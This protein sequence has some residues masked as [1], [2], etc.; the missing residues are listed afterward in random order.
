MLVDKLCELSTM[1]LTLYTIIAHNQC[2]RI[3]GGNEAFLSPVEQSVNEIVK[4]FD[5]YTDFLSGKGM[6]VTQ[7]MHYFHRLQTL[8]LISLWTGVK[9]EEIKTIT[10]LS[11][12]FGP[13]VIVT[14]EHTTAEITAAYKE[15]PDCLL[16]WRPMKEKS[17]LMINEKMRRLILQ[18]QQTTTLMA[19]EHDRDADQKSLL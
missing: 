13:S 7:V 1:E 2:Q 5:N 10:Q 3:Y 11:V 12:S 9:G 18:P 19:R 17:K 16:N 6:P 8:E 14:V 15:E 4:A